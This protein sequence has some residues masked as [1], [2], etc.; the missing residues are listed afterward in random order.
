MT[1]KR[2]QPTRERIEALIDKEGPL[3]CTEIAEKLGMHRETVRTILKYHTERGRFHI[4][5]WYRW[6]EQKQAGKPSAI[7]AV[8]PGINKPRPIIKDAAAEG[9]KRHVERYRHLINL[10]GRARRGFTLNV[11]TQLL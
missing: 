6:Y 4:V 10:R 3:H 7:Y 11:W 8:G 2:N 1:K 9:R 5:G